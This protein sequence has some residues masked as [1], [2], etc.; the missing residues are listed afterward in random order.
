MI[1]LAYYN[2]EQVSIIESIGLRALIMVQPN[3]MV[4]KWV[5]LDELDRIIWI[6]GK[7]KP[8]TA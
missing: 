2:Y 4:M 1:G 3:P 7:A 8:K 5:S 6:A